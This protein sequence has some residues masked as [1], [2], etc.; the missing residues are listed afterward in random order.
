MARK[1]SAADRNVDMF[2]KAPVEAAQDV[3]EDARGERLP[4]DQDVNRMREQAFQ[5]QEW[6]SKYFAS[7][8]A[9][10]D[11]YRVSLKDHHYYVETIKRQPGKESAYGYT[12]IMVHERN[13][14]NLTSVL[15]AAVRAKQKKESK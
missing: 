11:E 3:P 13:L 7:D 4:I 8:L 14:L 15:V 5:C 12:G 10:G 6:T 9:D 1:P 2:A